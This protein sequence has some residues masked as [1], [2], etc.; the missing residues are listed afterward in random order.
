MV[1]LIQNLMMIFQQCRLPGHKWVEV[2]QKTQLI[3]K[4]SKKKNNNVDNNINSN[5]N[6]NNNIDNNINNNNNNTPKIDSSNKDSIS[7]RLAQNQGCNVIGY[8]KEKKQLT[9]LLELSGTCEFVWFLFI[10]FFNIHK[11]NFL[12]ILML[13]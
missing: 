12:Y 9:N 4:T 3:V 7:K 8:E 11:Q 6:N 2:N 1:W 10:Y 5:N 13:F